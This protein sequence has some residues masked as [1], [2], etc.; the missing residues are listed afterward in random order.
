MRSAIWLAPLPLSVAVLA[1]CE[2]GS[3]IGTTGAPEPLPRPEESM[4]TSGQARIIDM[5]GQASLRKYYRRYGVEY[6]INV[7]QWDFDGDRDGVLDP[8]AQFEERF[9][10]RVPEGF[11]GVVALDWEHPVFQWFDLDPGSLQFQRALGGFKQLLERARRLRPE[12]QLGFYGL[13]KTSYW[14]RDATWRER[15]L[16]L[17]DLLQRTDWVG[18]RIY[19]PY[20]TGQL[21]EVDD[22]MQRAYA[23]ETVEIGLEVARAA[24][25]KP[26]YVWITHRYSPGND[27]HGL[28]PVEDAE[29][30]E[31]I[32]LV[33]KTEYRGRHVDGV[34]WW[35]G[36]TWYL[37]KGQMPPGE[38]S[39]T[40]I[41][42]LHDHYIELLASV[43]R[44][45]GR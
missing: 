38:R 26:V 39:Q 12:A 19:H 15:S 25:N 40:R 13:P 11:A 4:R 21:K 22:E 7:P 2:L 8:I 14:K 32:R 37:E 24:G 6:G 43:M 33:M 41:E 18:P 3:I 30:V 10:K 9:T 36:D 5:T 17:A 29:F 1:A 20:K 44:P 45:G 28:E 42:M 31:T 27:K 35:A 23:V 34:I 16:A